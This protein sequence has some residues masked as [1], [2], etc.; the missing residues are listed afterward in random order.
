MKNAP[1][2]PY[3]KNERK[4]FIIASIF[5]GFL[6]AIF[7][8][9][10]IAFWGEI[11]SPIGVIIFGVII[12]AAF[13]ANLV[14]ALFPRRFLTDRVTERSLFHSDLF[15]CDLEVVPDKVTA[16]YIKS[17]I[18]FFNAISREKVIDKSC[19]DLERI[20]EVGLGS[21]IDETCADVGSNGK[22]A[23]LKHIHLETMYIAAK[24]GRDPEGIEF[25]V[26]GEAD[27][28]DGFEIIVKG[29]KIKHIGEHT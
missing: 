7:I 26:S 25:S 20:R 17:C 23:I 24:E 1:L 13:V 9:M 10:L 8:A 27:W 11:Y 29:G 15:E 12:T 18:E 14:V 3:L 4:H 28:C 6:E 16:D 21:G 19:K 5:F 2:S 22:D